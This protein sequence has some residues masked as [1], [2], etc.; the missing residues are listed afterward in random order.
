M[1]SASCSIASNSFLRANVATERHN[2]ATAVT[3][4]YTNDLLADSTVRDRLELPV[5]HLSTVIPHL[6]TSSNDTTTSNVSNYTTTSNVNCL[7][8]LANTR[9]QTAAVGNQLAISNDNATQGL[10]VVNLETATVIS[11]KSD[12]DGSAEPRQSSE[13]LFTIISRLLTV[14]SS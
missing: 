13:Y 12:L 11:I 3:S 9:L 4:V 2:T 5:D 1:S 7:F 10:L 8:E 14:F 6:L